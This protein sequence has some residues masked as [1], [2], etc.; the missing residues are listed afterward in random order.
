[1]LHAELLND[2]RGREIGGGP[3]RSVIQRFVLTSDF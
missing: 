3:C 1:M 2:G